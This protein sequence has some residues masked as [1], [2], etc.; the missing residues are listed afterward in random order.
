[1]EIYGKH[2]EYNPLADG[3]Y[4][5]TYFRNGEHACEK[6]EATAEIVHFYDTE[7]RLTRCEYHTLNSGKA[8]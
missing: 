4:T 7:G 1:M 6:Q 5:V 2:A 8:H 3:N